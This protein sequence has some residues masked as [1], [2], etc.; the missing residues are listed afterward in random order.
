MMKKALLMVVLLLSVFA[1]T[2]LAASNELR[3]F[4]WSEYMDE[5]KMIAD[6]KAAT[7]ITVNLD[8]YES[9]EDMLAKLQAGG[10]SQYDIIVPSDYI[11][12]TLLAQKLIQPLDHS[13]IP[14]LKN[15][16]PQFQN[17]TFDPG[18]KFTAPWQ[19]GTVGLLYR[20][21]KISD[22]AAKS[23]SVYFDPKKQQGTFWFI[24]SV[25]D[26]MA[27]ALMY[28]GYD[29]NSTN[30]EEIKKAADLVTAAKNTKNCRGFKPGVGGKND[31]AAGSAAMAIV[32]NGDAMRAIS[33]E[34]GKLGFVIPKE[35]GEIW[36]DLMAIPAKAPNVE[37]AHKWINWILD[38]KVGAELSNFN[39]YATPNEA[40]L[41]FINAEDR[42][43]DG[44]YP[45]PETMKRLHFGKDLGPANRIMDEA[46][47][48]IKSH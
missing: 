6:F 41:P 35:G 17:T 43:E 33:E 9:N 5:K 10:V 38:P 23:W 32:Y 2:G 28:L 34:P 29:M 39:R 31:V 42:K 37:A 7:G 8:V 25:R 16:M 45:G 48:R 4:M 19:W 27:M 46:W 11:M 18:N 21:D 30:P 44:I 24:D 26:T 14:N 12:S 40:S 47:T 3:V 1:R 36:L 22:E 13:K 20:K 15:V